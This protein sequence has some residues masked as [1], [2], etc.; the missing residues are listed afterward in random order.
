MSK[1]LAKY[2]P[3]RFAAPSRGLAALLH[4]GALASFTRSYYYLAVTPNP[5]NEA[6]GW[7][8]QFLTIIGLAFATLTFIFG[9][10]SNIFLSQQLFKIKNYLSVASAPLEVLISLLYWGLRAI[11]PKLVL[12]EWAP[13]LPFS[14]D[15][16]LHAVPAIVLLIDILL[17]SPP[18][19]ITTLPAVGLSATI[20][21][22]YWFWVEAC[23][24]KN[25]FYPYPIFDEAGFAGRVGLFIG[26]G[27]IMAFGVGGI[28]GVY[29][30][31]NGSAPGHIKK[32]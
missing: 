7:H 12:P 5:I 22:V 16:G 20:A 6:Y 4:L 28:K 11:D 21:V 18:W 27:L 32:Q 30:I 15:L 13:I 2:N 19:T 8:F 3:Q 26:S 14:V 31:L 23:Y 25:G 24:A 29:G 1:S 10:L 17:F 9:L